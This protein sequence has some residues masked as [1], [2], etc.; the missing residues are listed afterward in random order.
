M[1][2]VKANRTTMRVI[3]KARVSISANFLLEE[4]WPAGDVVL[5]RRVSLRRAQMLPLEGGFQELRMRP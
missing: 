3:Q 4:E 1:T 2:P 5:S